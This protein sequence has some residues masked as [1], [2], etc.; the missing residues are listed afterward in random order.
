MFFGLSLLGF[1]FELKAIVAL[2]FSLFGTKKI[3]SSF[4]YWN[5]NIS[6][7]RQFFKGVIMVIAGFGMMLLPAKKV[8]VEIDDLANPPVE[9]IARVVVMETSPFM[10][11]GQ[12]L[13]VAVVQNS[14]S[15]KL[16]SDEKSE[17]HGTAVP[18][19]V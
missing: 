16:Q 3:I 2:V 9:V 19:L 17:G 1:A 11:S 10:I 15:R 18:P 4:K 12:K 14:S 8:Q 6:N 5:E 13:K 7:Q